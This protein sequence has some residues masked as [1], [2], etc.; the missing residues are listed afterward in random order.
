MCA[1]FERKPC[2]LVISL[3]LW[4]YLYSIIP[5]FRLPHFHV[6]R[7]MLLLFDVCNPLPGPNQRQ[8]GPW[9]SSGGIN[10]GAYRV[11]RTSVAL[12]SGALC[13]RATLLPR[14][15]KIM[16]NVSTDQRCQIKLLV[17]CA[18]VEGTKRRFHVGKSCKVSGFHGG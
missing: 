3:L 2:F 16:L 7:T 8:T 1:K 14:W 17:A 4:W 9:C 6:D 11:R 18:P 13:F 12:G 5:K 15:R 10:G